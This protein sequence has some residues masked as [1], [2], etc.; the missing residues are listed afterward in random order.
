MSREANMHGAYT[1][2]CDEAG[3]N[4]IDATAE[5]HLANLDR[6]ASDL[7]AL[8]ERYLDE[9]TNR[10]MKQVVSVLTNA[11]RCARFQLVTL[12]G[13]PKNDPHGDRIQKAVLSQIDYALT[14]KG[15][16]L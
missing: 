4:R 14:Q 11:L 16:G 13:D 2:Y 12:G 8:R 9:I 3:L 6:M 15:D 5:E 10:D 1:Y 7:L